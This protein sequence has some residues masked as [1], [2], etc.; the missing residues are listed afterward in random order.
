[1]ASESKTAIFAA[2]AG[3]LAIAV[4]KFVASAFTGSSAMLS[5]AIHSV[6]DTGNGGLML[7]GINRSEQP[8]DVEHPFGYGR[9]IYFWTLIV[10]VLI[11]GIGG[12]MSIYE[13]AMH[14]RAPTTEGDARWSYSVLGISAIFEGAGWYFGW[15]A[16][17]KEKGRRGVFEAI[18]ETKDPTSFTV[19]LEDSTALL[20]LLIAFLGVAGK[21]AGYPSLDAAAS[22]A[23]GLLLCAVATLMVYETKGLLIG[24]GVDRK[25][26]DRIREIIATDAAVAHVERLLTMY[27]GPHEVLLAIEIRMRDTL[28]AVEVRE[29]VVRLRGAIRSRF[30]DVKR[31]YF[32]AES[33][34]GAPR[35]EATAAGGRSG[36]EESRG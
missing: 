14:L 11:F 28:T 32:A 20:G 9:E 6:V 25:T 15:K 33:V 27:V 29:T 23:I 12:G 36:P 21:Q 22:I 30:P 1:M 8:P 4:T 10:A 18:H 19:L 2:I 7:F 34:G 3:N 13:G 31:V 5:E 17:R 35:L 16:F 24:E 26:L